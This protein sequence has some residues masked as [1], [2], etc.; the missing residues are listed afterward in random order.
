M[1]LLLA[2]L[3]LT[4]ACTCWA[5][6]V[7]A[8]APAVD[9]PAIVDA[10]PPPPPPPTSELVVGNGTRPVVLRRADNGHLDEHNNR[11]HHQ[12]E[13]GD[14]IL[15]L[16]LFTVIMSQVGL[17]RWRQWHRRSYTLVTLFGLWLI[18]I[19]ISYFATNVIRFQLIWLAFSVATI[20][21]IRKSRRTPLD[22]A[23]PRQVYRWFLTVHKV[24]YFMGSAG[25]L[26][27]LLGM[28]G[29]ATL[30]PDS[31]AV[32]PV[33]LLTY[34]LYFGVLSRDCAE[35]CTDTISVTLGEARLPPVTRSHF[36][37]VLVL[38]FIHIVV[39][40]QCTKPFTILAFG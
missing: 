14:A 12:H 37:C 7:V 16:S 27:L 20:L 3:V 2:V 39:C 31:I 40:K 35:Y 10:P 30:L 21:Q 33:Y 8:D 1:R 29:L 9:A 34:G 5:Q 23:T 17:Y 26:G 15:M 38:P 4:A 11:R 36:L 19:A 32:L 13:G 18:P 25:Y 24:C 22:A 28:M 6:D